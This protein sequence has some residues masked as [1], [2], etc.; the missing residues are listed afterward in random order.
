MMTVG[1]LP[2]DAETIDSKRLGRRLLLKLILSTLMV[3][4]IWDGAE[5]QTRTLVHPEPEGIAVGISI[6]FGNGSAWEARSEHGASYLTARAIGEELRTRLAPYGAQVRVSCDRSG[7]RFSLVV[8]PQDWENAAEGFLEEIFERTPSRSAI[9]R[10]RAGLIQ[11]LYLTEEALTLELRDAIAR[12]Q[13]HGDERWARAPCGRVES[14]REIGPTTVERMARSRFTAQRASAALVGPI[15]RSRGEALLRYYIP[16]TGLPLLTPKPSSIGR[17]GGEWV[18]RKTV[19]AWIGLSF[20]FGPDADIEA[21][22]LLAFILEREVEPHPARPE[23]Y[24]AR[25]EISRDGGGGSFVVYLIT[26]PP[27]AR[28]WEAQVKELIRRYAGEELAEPSFQTHLNRYRG[29]RLLSLERPEARAEDAALQ[30]FY[31]NGYISPWTRLGDLD[32]S[33]LSAAARALGPPVSAY[34]GPR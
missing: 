30:L 14:I 19:T 10:A 26:A 25:I 6:A 29:R 9:E 16:E 33:S 12:A 20:P 1:M 34:I 27:Q 23:I 32:P 4:T 22:N 11:E 21:L 18:E 24:D 28:E 3:A 5:A 8:P 31:E 2:S 17:G 7:I 13:Y 15:E